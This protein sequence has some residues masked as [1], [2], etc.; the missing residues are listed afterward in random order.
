MF[1]RLFIYGGQEWVLPNIPVVFLTKIAGAGG[2]LPPSPSLTWKLSNGPRDGR[3]GSIGDLLGLGASGCLREITQMNYLDLE[4]TLQ[5]VF[6]LCTPIF[7]VKGRKRA[8]LGV[9]VLVACI[10]L[11]GAVR[12]YRNGVLVRDM[13][14]VPLS[15][16]S[17]RV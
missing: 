1:G 13:A 15:L 17:A 5:F 16:S 11:E 4:R 14:V 9:Q 10:C 7:W 6:S 2:R 8:P 3:L 12:S